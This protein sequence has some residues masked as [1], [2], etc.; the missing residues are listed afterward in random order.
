MTSRN[1]FWFVVIQL[2]VVNVITLPWFFRPIPQDTGQVVIR[3]MYLAAGW[4]VI[5]GGII[6]MLKRWREERWRTPRHLSV[7]AD[8]EWRVIPDF[9]AYQINRAGEVWLLDEDFQIPSMRGTGGLELDWY[10]MYDSNGDPH[11]R[12]KAGLIMEAFLHA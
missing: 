6:S 10:E 12:S 5:L 1:W 7:P 4:F 11:L 9:P 3:S 8:D 2:F